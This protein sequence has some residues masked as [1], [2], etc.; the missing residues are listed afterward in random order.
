MHRIPS[1]G[2]PPDGLPSGG[3][4]PGGSPPGGLPPDGFR[5]GGP[6]PG[7]SP[8]VVGL[9]PWLFLQRLGWWQLSRQTPGWLTP[10]G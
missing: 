4:P 3:L 7:G 1:G 10:D 8:W 2:S 5:L 9:H 6:P